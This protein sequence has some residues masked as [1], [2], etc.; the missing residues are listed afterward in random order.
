MV[1][2]ENRYQA[3]QHQTFTGCEMLLVSGRK[4][5]EDGIR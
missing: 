1:C 2:P 5:S 3:L 4:D